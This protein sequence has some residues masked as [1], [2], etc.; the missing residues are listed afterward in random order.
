MRTL[1][2][3]LVFSALLSGQHPQLL[4]DA[5]DLAKLR[6][7]VAASDPDW[8]AT[9]AVC[10]ALLSSYVYWPSIDGDSPSDELYT[11]TTGST[12]GSRAAGMGN[13]Y[14]YE[15][16]TF[17]DATEHLGACY[18]ALRPTNPTAARLYASKAREIAGALTSAPILI[19]KGYEARY[20]IATRATPD[21]EYGAFYWERAATGISAGDTV[22]ISGATGCTNLNGMWTVATAGRSTITFFG[23]PL[24]NAECT[25]RNWNYT[26]DFNYGAR[27]Y[28]ESLSML[29]DWFNPELTPEESTALTRTMIYYSDAVARNGY[30]GPSTHPESN[31]ASS[32]TAFFSFCDAAWR[33]DDPAL[34]SFCQYQ[35]NARVFGANGQRDYFN[36]WLY[37]GGYGEGLASYGYNAIGNMTASIMAAWKEGTDWRLEPYNYNYIEDQAKYFLMASKPDRVSMDEQEYV[38]F[39]NGINPANPTVLPL[40]TLYPMVWALRK[41]ESTYAPYLQSLV[42]LVESSGVEAANPLRRFL[43][44]DAS[45][46]SADLTTLPKS[47]RSWGGNFATARSDWSPNAVVLQFQGGPSSG[48]AGNGKTQWESGAFAIWNGPNQFIVF[49]GGECSR[50]NDILTREQAD[51]LHNERRYYANHKVSIF[52]ADRPGTNFTRIDGLGTASPAPSQRPATTTHPTRIDRAEDAGGYAYYR[53]VGLAA[54]GS[55]SVNDSQYHRQAWTRQIL[56]IRPKLVVVYDTT[57]T[58]YADDDRAMFWQFGRDVTQVGDPAPGQHRFHATRN[59]GA[60][61]KGALTTVLP[62]NSAVSIV[63]HGLMS[64]RGTPRI[65]SFGE[66]L[67]F[68]YRVEQRPSAMNHSADRWLSVADAS[69]SV[70]AVEAVVSLAATNADVVQFSTSGVVGFASGTLPIKYAFTKAANHIIAGLNA[71]GIYHIS[72]SV[73]PAVTITAGAGTQD[74]KASEA[75]VLSF[76]TPT[77]LPPEAPTKKSAPPGNK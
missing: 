72:F 34:A 42:R 58:K 71:G 30:G 37:G 1:L 65:A 74:T 13:G 14:D 10:D 5:T 2:A 60:T 39:D 62:S 31:Y 29:Y 63:D 3:G 46:P 26:T 20:P 51:D 76:T 38:Y 11:W 73:G 16:G 50:S 59:S 32:W 53:S 23:L 64:I 66:S 52:A 47:Y 61:F 67:H 35:W 75:G 44:Y 57:A 48:S 15:G 69:K 12:E 70:D 36:R 68:L 25:N 22:T 6:A 33:N 40:S 21:A 49:G 77:V 55:A 28:G 18:L 8:Q 41:Q 56:F 24:P 17:R 4:L 43:Y 19:Q 54:V 27:F 45:A 9:K 7:K